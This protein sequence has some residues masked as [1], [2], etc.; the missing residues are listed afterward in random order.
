MLQ[1]RTNKGEREEQEEEEEEEEEREEAK[2]E[3][4]AQNT[5]PKRLKSHTQKMEQSESV[6]KVHTR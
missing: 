5:T 6:A 1:H 4:R 3:E 2:V